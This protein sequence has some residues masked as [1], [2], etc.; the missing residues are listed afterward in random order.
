[1]EK[2]RLKD[3]HIFIA[4]IYALRSYF[5]NVFFSATKHISDWRRILE[6]EE[7]QIKILLVSD[8]KEIK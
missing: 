3:S 8:D 1:M 2:Y 7:D 6:T 5:Y 4:F